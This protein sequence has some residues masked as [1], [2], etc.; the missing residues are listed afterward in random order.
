MQTCLNY[1]FEATKCH[2]SRNKSSITELFPM[3]P[4][5]EVEVGRSHILKDPGRLNKVRRKKGKKAKR[6]SLGAPW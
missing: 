2:F 3:A 6:A 5:D 4:S 1:N